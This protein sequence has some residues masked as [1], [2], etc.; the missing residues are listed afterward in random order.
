VFQDAQEPRER[1]CDSKRIPR[2]ERHERHESGH[3]NR[4]GCHGN[5]DFPPGDH[6]R[7]TGGP[8]C[9]HQ[10]PQQQQVASTWSLPPFPGSLPPEAGTSR[11]CCG[12]HARFDPQVTYF[13]IVPV[14]G[15][16]RP[17]C[18]VAAQPGLLGHRSNARLTARDGHRACTRRVMA[19]V[20]DHRRFTSRASTSARRPETPRS[21][22][23][24]LRGPD[25]ALFAGHTAA[26]PA[27]LTLARLEL[28]LLRVDVDY[29]A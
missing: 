11:P 29:D 10:E 12:P 3:G 2:P 22:F 13:P 17:C 21:S 25:V 15:P 23:R 4:Q 20:E 8:A 14:Y 27:S 9:R 24:T 1:V 6:G 7:F 19:C 26:L 18:R 28:A 5:D 16:G